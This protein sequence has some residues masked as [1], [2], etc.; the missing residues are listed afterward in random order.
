MVGGLRELFES[1]A[2]LRLTRQHEKPKSQVRG[3]LIELPM[4][5]I[6]EALR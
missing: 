4:G 1:Q 3:T 6:P 2:A 5:A